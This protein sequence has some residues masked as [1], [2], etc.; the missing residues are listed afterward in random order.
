VQLVGIYLVFACL[1]VPALATRR[2]DRRGLRVLCG[3]LVGITGCLAG[4]ALSVTF[5]L[6][7]GAVIVWCLATVAV[8]F[9]RLLW[10]M[11]RRKHATAA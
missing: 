8:G 3:Y 6:P 2:I 11:M 1:I 7:A 9:A 5:D 10:P 4:L